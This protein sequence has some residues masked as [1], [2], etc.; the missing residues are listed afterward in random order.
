MRRVPGRLPCVYEK[1]NFLGR[2]ADIRAK[3]ATAFHPLSQKFDIRKD[4]G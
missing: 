3:K 4:R 1:S 2:K